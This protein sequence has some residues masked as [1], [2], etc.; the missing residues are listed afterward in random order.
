MPF[1]ITTKKLLL[2]AGIVW[3][4]AGSNIVNIG[5][6]AYQHEAGWIIAALVLGSLAVFVLFHTR[7]FTKMVRKHS[8]RIQ[9]YLSEK[10]SVLKF[11]DA[12][13]Y[14]MMAIMMGGGI[15]LRVSGF[16]PEWLIAFFYTG[17]GAALVVA[18]ISFVI[19][20]AKGIPASCP[21]LP[22]AFMRD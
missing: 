2:V 14:L 17:L 5:I 3:F 8:A 10:T 9:G 16:A 19:R 4:I 20:Y 6:G 18:G 13:G 1:A 15:A 22:S 12:K 11:F 7:I 21:A